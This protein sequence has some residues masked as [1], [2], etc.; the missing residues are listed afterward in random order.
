M[1]QIDAQLT[2]L[3]NTADSLERSKVLR[4]MKILLNEID[5]LS[6]ASSKREKRGIAR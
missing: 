1:D 4:R 6:L 5:A 3:N 2:I